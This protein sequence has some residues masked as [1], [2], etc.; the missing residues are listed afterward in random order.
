MLLYN[1]RY[2]YLVKNEVLCIF[3]GI[4]IVAAR[5]TAFG[6]YG[7]TLKDHSANDL[8]AIA[9]SAALKAGNV[10]PSTVDAV[11]TG[12]VMQVREFG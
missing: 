4:F 9:N 12:N 3:T 1:L 8:Q 6:T 11:Y 7:G 5:R 10:D 2:R